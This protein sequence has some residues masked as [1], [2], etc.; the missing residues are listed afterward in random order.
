MK[1]FVF[2]TLLLCILSFASAVLPSSP[3]ANGQIV[4][5]KDFDD[6][7]RVIYDGHT[8]PIVT[9]NEH[10]PIFLDLIGSNPFTYTKILFKLVL[11]PASTEYY[12]IV[13]NFDLLKAVSLITC[14]PG[15]QLTFETL[16]VLD[17]RQQWK[18]I[19]NLDGSFK[20]QNRAYQYL[21]WSSKDI[22]NNLFAKLLISTDDGTDTQKF[23]L[24]IFGI[25]V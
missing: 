2:C 19:D 1:F 17:F 8:S 4:V 11:A 21:Y 5:F 3:V 14:I 7:E 23:R 15:K 12:N 13:S 6:V 20:I 10:Q 9:V 24:G 22:A 18:F 16:D 25:P